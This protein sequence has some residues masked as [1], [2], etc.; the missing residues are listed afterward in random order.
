[1]NVSNLAGLFQRNGIFQ[2]SQALRTASRRG[3][4]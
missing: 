4:E 1:M 2:Q 3:T